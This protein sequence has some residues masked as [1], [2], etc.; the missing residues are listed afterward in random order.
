VHRDPPAGLVSTL[1]VKKGQALRTFGQLENGEVY[2]VVAP[3][4]RVGI[5]A[6]YRLSELW[7]NPKHFRCGPDLR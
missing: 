2:A 3:L 6:N 5:L 7:L 1:I 4:K